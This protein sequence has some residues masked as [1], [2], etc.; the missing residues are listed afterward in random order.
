MGFPVGALPL[1]LAANAEESGIVLREDTGGAR[2]D[3]GEGEFREAV[4]GGLAGSLSKVSKQGAPLT[5]SVIVHGVEARHCELSH[6]SLNDP[7]GTFCELVLFEIKS[8]TG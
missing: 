1:V 4:W 6:F 7:P 8:L 5:N 2:R 3:P